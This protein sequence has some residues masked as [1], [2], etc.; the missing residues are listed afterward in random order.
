MINKKRQELI[1]QNLKSISS[2]VRM[3]AI[4]QLVKIPTLAD[5]KKIEHLQVVADDLD[6]TVKNYALKT[7][8]E[9]GADVSTPEESPLAPSTAPVEPNQAE[10]T[11]SDSA[12]DLNQGGL[13]ALD[14]ITEEP[15]P[16]KPGGLTPPPL[17]QNV[18]PPVPPLPGLSSLSPGT[19][20]TSVPKTPQPP[21]SNTTPSP[22]LSRPQPATQSPSETVPPPLQ[23]SQGEKILLDDPVDP[24]LPDISKM[25]DI[26]TMLD[27][28][29]MLSQKRPSGHI[30]QLLQLA[31]DKQEEVSLTALQA[32]FSL[33]DNRV[34]PQVLTMLN[35]QSLS[36]QR[37]FLI[38]KIVM[39]TA[40]QLDPK[41][42]EKIL[43]NEKDVIVKSGLVKVFARC[44]GSSGRAAL[45]ECL[46][47]EDPRVRANTVEVIEEQKIPGCDG[48]ILQLLEDSENRVKVNSA[49]YLIKNGYTQAFHTLKNMLMSPEVWIRDSVIF[50]LGEIGDPISIKLLK[51]A[52]KDSNQGIRL[53]ALK[54]F[55]KINTELSRKILQAATGDPDMVV[56][57]VAT[58]LLAK[59]KDTPF[60]EPFK[61]PECK[62]SADTNSQEH[63]STE[64]AA[65]Q[66]SPTPN[67]PT[68]STLDSEPTSLPSLDDADVSEPRIPT[69]APQHAQAAATPEHQPPLAPQAT[70]I[71]AQKQ[72]PPLPD[73]LKA[74]LE[75]EPPK[76]IST[77]PTQSLKPPKS[78]QT[79]QPPAPPQQPTTQTPT[80]SAP[81]SDGSM[82]SFQKPRS[83]EIY[84]RL[85]SDDPEQEKSAAR[86]I[87]F[88]MGDDQIILLEKGAQSQNDSIRLAVARIAARKK[89]AQLQSLL[90]RL[91]ADPSEL[92][93]SVAKKALK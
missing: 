29:K 42:L 34:A 57:Q 12:F 46:S 30:T 8:K 61:L 18:K 1:I 37:R 81:P 62:I 2:E 60:K 65:Q 88:V 6:E 13:P 68:E 74:S 78:T 85:C 75:V 31:S 5:D 59:V 36:S 58:S 63:T 82:P 80:V 19:P 93:N 22:D 76:N 20:N 10:T 26:S 71:P 49:K 17:P 79:L 23:T 54:A 45:I 55:S 87:A 4:D 91:A 28:I 21:P 32:L 14:S 73:F 16:Q 52:L 33:N 72:A 84:K 53:S 9:L 90:Q 24:S 27:H 92:V 43:K 67:L 70:N 89:N 64:V 38:L 51:A 25:N 86:D 56:A 3:K 40:E 41:A 39:N 15:A 47:D 48:K 83:A 66:E 35:D 7:L 44:S 50:A 77:P 11:N 69:L